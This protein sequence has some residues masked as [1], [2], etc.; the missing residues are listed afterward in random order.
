MIVGP[1]TACG[2]TENKHGFGW[3]QQDWEN[4]YCQPTASMQARRLTPRECERLQGF[5]DGWTMIPWRGKPA[6]LCPDGPRYKAIGNSWAVNV[7][8]WLGARID[9]AIRDL[10]RT[11]EAQ[12]A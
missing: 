4:G 10:N 8:A 1:M 9:A 11:Q 12:A 2:G 5:P 3:G 7:A 6:E